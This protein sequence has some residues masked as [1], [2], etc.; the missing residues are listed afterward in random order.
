MSLNFS[1]PPCSH[2][3]C[4]FLTKLLSGRNQLKTVQKVWNKLLRTWLYPRQPW[5]WLNKNFSAHFQQR[6][7]LR[8]FLRMKI[9]FCFSQSV[10]LLPCWNLSS[11]FFCWTSLT[12]PRCCKDVG[13]QTACDCEGIRKWSSCFIYAWV[14]AWSYCTLFIHHNVCTALVLFRLKFVKLQ[15]GVYLGEEGTCF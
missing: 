13:M 1:N 14:T 5:L 10:C 2:S 11:F 15:A 12:G 7:S 6:L 4:P 9:T 3:K 8:H